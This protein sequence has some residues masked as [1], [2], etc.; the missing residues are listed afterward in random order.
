MIKRVGTFRN[1]PQLAVSE[2]QVPGSV[3]SH[4][5]VKDLRSGIVGQGDAPSR[6][7][8][9][10][11]AVFE[12]IE[13]SV[14]DEAAR[15]KNVNSSGWA[16]H[17]TLESAQQGAVKELCERDAIMVTWMLKRSPKTI[18]ELQVKLLNRDFPL[19]HFATYGTLVVAGTIIEVS[20][21]Q[22]MLISAAG[23]QIAD[24]IEKLSGEAERA[25]L[26]LQNRDDLHDPKLQVHHLSFCSAD[27][28][29]LQWLFADGEVEILDLPQF[30]FQDFEA[31]LWDGTVA[32]VSHA[33][34][35][36]LQRL[37]WGH[38]HF[39]NLNRA[40]LRT[41]CSRPYRLNRMLHP[42]L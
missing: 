37:Y 25:A 12:L 41:S 33:C 5:A 17:R 20:S 2:I 14:F 16:A 13:R 9:Q 11:K 29:D 32:Y 4:F 28:G 24:C 23:D 40:R 21:R 38:S 8:A 1:P 19:F 30:E 18:G 35:S 31:E 39:S 3:Y 6:E 7:I 22:R 34:S 42:I 36:A 27:Q 26:I 15:G 10:T